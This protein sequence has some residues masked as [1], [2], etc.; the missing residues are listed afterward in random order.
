MTPTQLS[1]SCQF[2]YNRRSSPFGYVVELKSCPRMP[3]SHGI[4]EHTPYPAGLPPSPL[5]HLFLA[6]L[7]LRPI[8]WIDQA[9]IVILSSFPELC[10][11]AYIR[12]IFKSRVFGWRMSHYQNLSQ[13]SP[14]IA[15]L[16]VSK[17]V[18]GANRTWRG[19]TLLRLRQI[20]WTI[21]EISVKQKGLN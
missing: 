10:I 11:S 8:S 15:A 17:S 21:S 6:L 20:I 2:E 13:E 5:S 3:V 1:N 4:N 14:N 9:N 19:E 7:A 12:N 16:A 18:D